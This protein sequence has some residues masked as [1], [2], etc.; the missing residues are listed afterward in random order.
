[1]KH[2]LKL[3]AEL[4]SLKELLSLFLIHIAAAILI[5]DLEVL[6]YFFISWFL[7]GVLLEHLSEVVVSLTFIK[8]T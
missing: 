6:F 1:M 4:V 8:F 5:H 2:H 3:I 7:T